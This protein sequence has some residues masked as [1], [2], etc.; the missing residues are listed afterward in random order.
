MQSAL[1]PYLTANYATNSVDL[2]S[3]TLSN[4]VTMANCLNRLYDLSRLGS[5]G[6][7]TSI[8]KALFQIVR[9]FQLNRCSKH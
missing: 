5:Q 8:A 2:F 7:C 9:S 4:L 3:M 6:G 1:H